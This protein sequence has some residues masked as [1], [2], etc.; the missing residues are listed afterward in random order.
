[1]SRSVGSVIFGVTGVFDAFRSCIARFRSLGS[2]MIRDLVPLFSGKKKILQYLLFVLFDD[3]VSLEIMPPLRSVSIVSL[4]KFWR[5]K[6][7][8]G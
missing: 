3:D 6:D 2:I 1:M 5:K 7:L 4:S 8:V